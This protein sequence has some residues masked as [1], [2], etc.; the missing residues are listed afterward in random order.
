MIIIPKYT[1][2][3]RDDVTAVNNVLDADDNKLDDSNEVMEVEDENM[4]GFDSIM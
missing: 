3:Q 4:P 1:L 2:P